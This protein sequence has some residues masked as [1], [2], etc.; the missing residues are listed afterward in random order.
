M[1]KDGHQIGNHSWSHPNLAKLKAKKI[2]EELDS[3]QKLIRKLGYKGTCVV[4]PPYGSYNNV[5]KKEADA[6][7]ILWNVDTE[8]WR[9]K[10]DVKTIYKNIMRDAHDGAIIL[11][12][13]IY[14]SSVDAALKAMDKL[15]KEGY[16]FVTVEELFAIRG[17]K[18]KNGK[19]YY[20]APAGD[21]E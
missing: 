8:D 21:K 2:N 13:D 19:I 16:Q 20:N 6:P 4:R 14:G 9:H 11:L 3:T 5:V 1:I 12:H 18:M 17:V 7:I 10:G 15:E